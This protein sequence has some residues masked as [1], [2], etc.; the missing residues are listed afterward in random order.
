M[1]NDIML[2]GLTHLYDGDTDRRQRDTDDKAQDEEGASLRVALNSDFT[3]HELGIKCL[4]LPQQ[5][6]ISRPNKLTLVQWCNGAMQGKLRY[7]NIRL[8]LNKR[9]YDPQCWSCVCVCVSCISTP[10]K[11]NCQQ[12]TELP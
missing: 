4:D 1:S 7:G 9:L 3:D 11:S 5:E 10:I 8:S 6:E 12:N 2:M